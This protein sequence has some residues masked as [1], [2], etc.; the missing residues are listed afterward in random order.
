ML[1]MEQTNNVMTRRQIDAF[2]LSRKGTRD[3]IRF[4]LVSE[5]ESYFSKEKQVYKKFIEDIKLQLK[6]QNYLT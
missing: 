4:L 1:R 3:D 2:I 5:D 6:M